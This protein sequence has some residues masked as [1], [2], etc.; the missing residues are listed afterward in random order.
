VGIYP[1]RGYDVLLEFWGSKQTP[2]LLTEPRVQT[3]VIH[4]PLMLAEIYNNK[5]YM[6]ED[7]KF[8]LFTTREYRTAR[9]K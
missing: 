7:G 2:I 5:Q 4:L 8:G 1:G 3:L 9:L 6:C